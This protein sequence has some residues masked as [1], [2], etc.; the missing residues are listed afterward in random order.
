MVIT[1]TGST[2]TIGRELVRLLS[3]RG[4][5]VRA[6]LRDFTKARQ[7]EHVAWIQ[8]DLAE[9]DK[10]D[11]V[12]AG[13]ERLFLLTDN[14]PGFGRIQ[15][16][17]IRAAERLGVH[18]VVKL[19][20]LGASGHSRAPLAREHWE[21]EQVLQLSAMT[22]TI[23]RPHSF[24]QNWLGDV[25]E[26]VRAERTIYSAIG[27]GRVPFIDARDI[28]DVAV[29][30][31]LHPETH[32]DRKYVLTGGEAIGYADLARVLSETLGET[33]TYRALSMEEARAR[34]EAAG[35]PPKSI[36]SILALSAYQKAGGP[37]ERTSDHVQ[38]ILGRPPRTIRDFAR[39]YREH[40]TA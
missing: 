19:S 5:P 24:M 12:L 11:A 3:E 8:A 15:I 31:L 20:A 21:V 16:E 25:A 32:A 17:V 39:D 27:D 9:K 38:Q 29:E 26:S 13:T 4:Q 22:W 30:T 1:V 14:T 10:L 35:V 36:E 7:L 2:G 23:L 18:H 37:T 33:V 34:M 28:A 40:F 6:V